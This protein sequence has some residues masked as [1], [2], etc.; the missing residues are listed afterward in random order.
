MTIPNKQRVGI[1]TTLDLVF[2]IDGTGSMQNLLDAIKNNA[3]TL[4]NRITEALATKQRTVEVIRVKVAV[5]RDI[6]V[7]TDWFVESDFFTLPDEAESFR[8]FVGSIKATGGG[9]APES[10][11]EAL[12]NALHS[13]WNNDPNYEKKRQIIMLMTDTSA[14]SLEDPQR[15]KD[16]LYPQGMPK[17]MSELYSE[18]ADEGIIGQHAKRLAIFAP[19]VF[20]WNDM[21]SDWDW[22]NLIVC[23]AGEG[24]TEEVMEPVIAYIKGSF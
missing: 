9:D 14:H 10:G 24:M 17:N 1:G 15:D 12:H 19:N 7:D 6:Y 20:P 2:L 11:L 3:L 4:H 18:W 5:F 21:Q 16:P 13:E 8:S 23:A 22:I